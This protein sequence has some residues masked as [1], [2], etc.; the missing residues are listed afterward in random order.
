[1]RVGQLVAWALVLAACGTPTPVSPDDV[2]HDSVPPADEPADASPGASCVVR[3]SAAREPID[4][5][6][7]EVEVAHILV[8]WAEA[9]RA[10]DSITRTR[11]QACLRA[12]EALDALQTGEDFAELAGRFSDEDGAA[13]RGGMLGE[14]E[15]ADVA[16]PFADAAFRLDVNQ[17]SA[18]VE[19]PFGFHV[20]LRTR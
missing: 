19:S 9:E 5:E 3:A 8:K 15:R 17:V 12:Q 13:S 1:M 10:P 7:H 6:P 11:E 2:A 16:P 18:V 4:D 14:I 20:V